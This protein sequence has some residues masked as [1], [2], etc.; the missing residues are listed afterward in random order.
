MIKRQSIMDILHR[1]SIKSCRFDSEVVV[2]F[3]LSNTIIEFLIKI[4]YQFT[5]PFNKR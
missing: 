3:K 1:F 5:L 4:N 2:N